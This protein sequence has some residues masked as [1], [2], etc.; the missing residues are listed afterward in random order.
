V[1]EKSVATFQRI[2]EAEG[3]IHG[4]PP[5]DVTFH[6]VGALDSIADIACV[7][8]A[9][10]NLKVDRVIC[11]PLAEGSGFVQC[12]HGRFPIPAPATLEILKGVPLRIG[13]EQC[14]MITPT[15]AAIAREYATNFEAMPEIVVE[16]IGYGAGTRNPDGRP[17]VLRAVLGTVAE[18][19]DDRVSDTVT[20]IETNIDD[21]SP[22]IA[23]SVMERLM[24]GKALEASY[25]PAFMK[26]NRPGFVL[27]VICNPADAG[28]IAQFILS[29]TSSF[30]VR[31]HDCRRMKLDREIVQVATVEGEIAVKIG[32]SGG[33]VVQVAP[34]YESCAAASRASGRPLR[35]VYA[36]AIAA[37]HAIR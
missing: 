25:V 7:A 12:A 15:G 2:A 19:R 4:K 16:K 8:V 11:S 18:V 1:K 29:E 14:E 22:E 5:Q 26:K 31:M 37:W 28:E 20:V 27:S 30:G 24:A 33:K 9:M 3:R 23:G 36:S 34:E 35:E 32:R 21:L 10:E 17:N 13:Q 6:E